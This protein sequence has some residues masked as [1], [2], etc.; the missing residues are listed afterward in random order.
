MAGAPQFKV[1]KAGGE[2]MAAC[3]EPEAAAAIV[4]LYGTGATIRDGHK[5]SDT[6]W[7][8]GEAYDGSAG[9][10]YDLVAETVWRIIEER[11]QAREAL[12]KAR[13]AARRIRSRSC[14]SGG[15]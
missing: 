14:I 9:D 4:S 10:S 1:Y 13:E 12:R 7:T 15:C 3:K 2:Y 6:V 5:K 8:E 11:R